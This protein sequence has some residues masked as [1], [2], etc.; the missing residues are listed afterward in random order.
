M[1]VPESLSFGDLKR[2]AGDWKWPRTA[3]IGEAQHCA[4]A[5]PRQY[6]VPALTQPL[7]RPLL[8]AEPL[9]RGNAPKKYIEIIQSSREVFGTGSATSFVARLAQC[10]FNGSSTV[11]QRFVSAASTLLQLFLG[12]FLPVGFASSRSALSA[13]NG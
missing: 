11:R 9:Q 5:G 2:L 10:R 1:N 7:D 8:Q 3:A 4:P 6:R 13:A 12:F